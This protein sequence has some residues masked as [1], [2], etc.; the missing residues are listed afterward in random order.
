MGAEKRLEPIGGSAYGIP[1]KD[2]TPLDCWPTNVPAGA[3]TDGR[4]SDA[5][6]HRKQQTKTIAA[7]TFI[8][9]QQ[10][11]I[12]QPYGTVALQ[13]SLLHIH[14]V[15]QVVRRSRLSRAPVELTY[16]LAPLVQSCPPER[17][18]LP[19][20]TEGRAGGSSAVLLFTSNHSSFFPLMSLITSRLQRVQSLQL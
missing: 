7:T 14:I 10:A 16:C 20:I 3:L 12:D 15:V 18:S 2:E 9:T 17:P 5:T 13:L 6:L 4:S 1:R 8:G 11:S 19:L